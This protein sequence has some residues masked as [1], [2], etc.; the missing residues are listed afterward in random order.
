VHAHPDDEAMSTGGTLARYSAEGVKTILVTCTNG[1][2]GDGD[3]GAKPGEEGHD[4][5]KVVQVRREELEESCRILGISH[6]E[7]LGFRD[8]GMMGWDTNHDPAAFWNQPVEKAAEPL[9]ALLERYSPQVV[10]TYD[11][12]GFYGHPDHIQAHRITLAALDM[13][14]RPVKIYFPTVRRS[15]LE[16]FRARMKEAGMEPPEMDTERFGSADEDIDATIDCR[17]FAQQ[18]LAALKAHASQ[19]ENIFFTR[20]S[21]EDFREMFCV[22]EFIRFRDWTGAPVPEDDLFSGIS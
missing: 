1:E 7:M 18:K 6:L 10:V 20:F 12:F 2:M 15:L 19:G 17:A 11:D 13:V 8:S 16:G 3:G 21:V 9:A 22:E 14:G 4:V 5:E